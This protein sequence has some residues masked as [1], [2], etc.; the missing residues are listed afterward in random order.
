[1]K[2]IRQDVEHLYL[3]NDMQQYEFW[4]FKVE[5]RP[6]KYRLSLKLQDKHFPTLFITMIKKND[7]AGT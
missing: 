5:V 1:M 6:I 3:F 7:T 4:L 2:G